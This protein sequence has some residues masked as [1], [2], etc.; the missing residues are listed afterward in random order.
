MFIMKSA[1]LDASALD[2]EEQTFHDICMIHT[3]IIYVRANMLSR[4]FQAVMMSL[5]FGGKETI[6]SFFRYD[7][8]TWRT[9][10]EIQEN[11]KEVEDTE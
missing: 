9:M 5:L 1:N 7:F 4:S 3:T 6:I 11:I 10:N 2:S 8:L